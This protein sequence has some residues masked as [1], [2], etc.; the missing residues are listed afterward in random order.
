MQEI[1]AQNIENNMLFGFFNSYHKS[2]Q[3][4]V[5]GVL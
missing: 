3:E 4:R 2:I 1:I 5:R